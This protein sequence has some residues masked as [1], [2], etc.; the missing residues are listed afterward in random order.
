[1]F[2]RKL[3]M[4]ISLALALGLAAFL[5]GR[6]QDTGS[7]SVRLA[8]APSPRA[9]LDARS[10]HRIAGDEQ[11]FR[12]PHPSA[13]SERQLLDRR[14]SA[15]TIVTV[16]QGRLHVQ[17]HDASLRDLLA[18]ISRKTGTSISFSD[19]V[20]EQRV[21][22]AFRN[23]P[24]G[25]GLRRI[26]EGQ[27]IFF[28]YGASAS[29]PAALWVYPRGKG[30]AIVPAPPETW[31]ATAELEQELST[32]PDW[33]ARARA[34]EAV[35]ERKG[36]ESVD[37]VQYALNDPNH[38]VRYSALSGALA[39]GLA[40]PEG[41]LENLAQYDP[42]PYVRT[43]AL[44]AIG[45]EPGVDNSQ[46]RSMAEAALVDPN[47]SVRSQARDILSLLDEGNRPWKREG[48]ALGGAGR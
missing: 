38:N 44:K 48:R 39:I 24:L 18:E 32:N 27:D 1:M 46:V 23:L 34:I 2:G 43:L 36:R 41:T 9:Q 35:I 19:G 25:E 45:Q 10:P 28:F 47:P 37:A 12:R 33:G 22:I 40:L 20:R 5:Y 6:T 16:R 8:P 4:T 30:Q 13:S 42:S 14:H 26:L 7:D 21:S 17:A 31:A 15:Q 29:E 11:S 3:P